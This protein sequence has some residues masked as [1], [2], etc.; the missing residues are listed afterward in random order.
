MLTTWFS[1]QILPGL[2]SALS[3]AVAGAVIAGWD[4]LAAKLLLSKLGPS[5]KTIYNI[6]DPILDGSLQGWKD[7]DIDTAI[8]LAIEIAYDGK[9]SVE[10]INK[11]VKLVSQQWIP[12][13]ASEKIASGV[14]GTKELAVAEKIRTAVETKS[15]NAPELLLL[16]KKTYVG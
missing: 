16:L 5:A 11:I 1:T 15:I 13:I 12:Q 14:I 2:V 4:K 6:V 7:S 8:A 10:E 9:L 3:G